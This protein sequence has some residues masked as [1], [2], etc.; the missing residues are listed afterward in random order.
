MIGR[1]ACVGR[2][3]RWIVCRRETGGLALVS[4]ESECSHTLFDVLD[5][6]YHC[7][8]AYGAHQ[9]SSSQPNLIRSSS[10]WVSAS[11]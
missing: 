9:I 10:A 4:L 8:T 1:V 6:F 2:Y 3:E 7:I 11:S 5:G